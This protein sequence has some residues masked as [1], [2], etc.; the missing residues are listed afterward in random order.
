[1]HSA[2]RC[3]DNFRVKYICISVG[4]RLYH[5]R[6]GFWKL[7]QCKFSLFFLKKSFPFFIGGIR[8]KYKWFP[9]QYDCL[10]HL[11]TLQKYQMYV[12][13]VGSLNRSIYRYILAML[14]FSKDCLLFIIE[15]EKRLNKENLCRIENGFRTR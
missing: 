8:S 13:T 7:F 11:E 1:M 4:Q 3:V 15:C 14:C 10:L 6:F 9:T 2:H 5:D 12:S